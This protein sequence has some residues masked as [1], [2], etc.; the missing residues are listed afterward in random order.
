[1]VY[2]GAFYLAAGDTRRRREEKKNAGIRYDALPRCK[3][4][5]R[6]AISV[7]RER[8]HFEFDRSLV[9]D[10]IILPRLFAIKV[11]ARGSCCVRS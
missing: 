11:I 7:N 9:S 4:V 5:S 8:D 10:S 6:R 3:L 1:M 2:A